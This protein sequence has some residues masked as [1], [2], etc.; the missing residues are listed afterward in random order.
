MR[1]LIL[2]FMIVFLAIP[3][4]AQNN[5]G[6]DGSLTIQKKYPRNYDKTYISIE[7]KKRY[8]NIIKELRCAICQRH[9]LVNSKAPLAVDLRRNIFSMLRQG[10]TDDE[11]HRLLAENFG[12]FI[13]YDDPLEGKDYSLWFGPI[14]LCLLAIILIIFIIRRQKSPINKENI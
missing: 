1:I 10:K 14:A 9:D 3:A 2:S 11:I 6:M 4:S 8:R 7:H 13:L 5:F 12:E